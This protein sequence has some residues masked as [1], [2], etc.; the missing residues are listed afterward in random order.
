[1]LKKYDIIPYKS[2]NNY[3]YN[4]GVVCMKEKS[5]TM[6]SYQYMRKNAR[7]GIWSRK[8]RLKHYNIYYK[9]FFSNKD[10]ILKIMYCRLK[11]AKHILK[12]KIIK[13]LWRFLCLKK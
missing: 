7:G 1:M 9:P 11:K 8:N 5:N 2:K 13:F 3:W 4:M 10:F 12:N 6:K